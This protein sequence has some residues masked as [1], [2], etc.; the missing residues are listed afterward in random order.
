MYTLEQAKSRIM[1]ELFPE[2]SEET[3][4]ENK[5]MIIDALTRETSF[6]WVFFYNNQ[7]YIE[8][9]DANYAWGGPGPILFNKYTGAL[10]RYGAAWEASGLILDYEKEIEAGEGN[11]VI[12][13][14]AEQEKLKVVLAI[15]NVF[16]INQKEALEMV[17]QLPCN[18]Y[19][20]KWKDLRALQQKFEKYGVKT[21]VRVTAAGHG[22]PAYVE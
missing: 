7:K 15:K 13:L 10:K 9:N 8:T 2:A 6:G 1:S 4:P 16:S 3:L 17:S 20:G 5:P 12:T 19:S 11:W 18:L 14:L 22:C 21:E